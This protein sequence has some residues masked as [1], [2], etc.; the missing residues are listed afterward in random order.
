MSR[1]RAGRGLGA[2]STDTADVLGLACALAA[3]VM[4][5]FLSLVVVLERVYGTLPAKGYNGAQ[6]MRTEQPSPYLSRASAMRPPHH[7]VPRASARS[8]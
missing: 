8:S 6:D 3:M 1:L 5:T 7:V 2:P 4:L